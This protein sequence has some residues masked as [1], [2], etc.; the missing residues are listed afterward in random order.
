MIKQT[1]TMHTE[2][3]TP[4]IMTGLLW[5]VDESEVESSSPFSLTLFKDNKRQK[6]P[7]AMLSEG[8]LIQNED[9]SGQLLIFAR[10]Q[11]IFDCQQIDNDETSTFKLTLYEDGTVSG[12]IEFPQSDRET[13]YYFKGD[14]SISTT[15]ISIWGVW[16]KEIEFE[17]LHA[18]LI[19]FNKII[20]NVTLLNL[21]YVL[22]AEE[23]EID[24]EEV[25][26]Y[27]EIDEEKYEIDYE[28]VEYIF[29]N[30]SE[31]L[32]EKLN[33]DDIVSILKLVKDYFDE[34]YIKN[35]NK[36]PYIPF[37]LKP[38]E[39][40]DIDDYVYRNAAKH[41]LILNQEEV[42]EIMYAVIEY[43]EINGEI[44]DYAHHLN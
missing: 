44:K 18:I 31:E 6:A 35:E 34:E 37:H 17:E 26:E 28:E 13:V 8:R 25:E 40:D 33:I 24:E 27:D 7:S 19:E 16:A 41:N 1:K 21:V 5:F 4:N 22:R 38:V 23:G 42:E 12:R 15:K 43:N 32:S 36:K 9:K 39:T 10:Q 14:Y 30:I 29:E 2:T 20:T 11:L 3:Y